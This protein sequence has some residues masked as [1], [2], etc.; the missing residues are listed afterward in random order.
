MLAEAATLTSGSITFVLAIAGCVGMFYLARR[1]RTG[2]L[3]FLAVFFGAPVIMVCLA[4]L[5]YGLLMACG[6]WLQLCE[7]S[8]KGSIG[9]LIVCVPM[10]WIAGVAGMVSEPSRPPKGEDASRQ[11][12][13]GPR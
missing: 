5:S 6:T 12:G 8:V 13:S 3:A 11:P 10:L 7:P 1:I 9:T 4:F 2:W